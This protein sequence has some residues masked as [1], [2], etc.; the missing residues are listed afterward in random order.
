MEY[1]VIN[2]ELY[3]HGIKGMK[4][5]VRR[6]QNPDGSL[7]EAGLKRYGN[8]SRAD[9]N[10]LKKYG[11]SGYKHIQN[12]MKLGYSRDRARLYAQDRKELGRRRANRISRRT[13]RFQEN[14]KKRFKDSEFTK[15]MSDTRYHSNS[16][17]IEKARRLCKNALLVSGG[18]AVSA[19]AIQHR[20]QIAYGFKVAKYIYQTTKPYRKQY[21]NTIKT[22]ARNSKQTKKFAKN[23]VKYGYKHGNYTKMAARLNGKTSKWADYAQ[24]AAFGKFH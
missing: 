3:H 7:T 18:I 14:V 6:Y 23:A 15:N 4:W 21:A 2:G 16:K 5:G 11:T 13:D 22:M 12:Q 1:I 8:L 10:D 24:K 20:K 19:V 17:A 9:R